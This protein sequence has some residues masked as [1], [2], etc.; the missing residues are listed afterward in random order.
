MSKKLNE[1]D[2]NYQILR[3]RVISQQIIDKALVL[4]SIDEDAITEEEEHY[5][6]VALNE[7]VS[8][9]VDRMCIKRLP[10][11]VE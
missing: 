2:P 10:G 6:L 5:M 9:W 8:E 11:D 7:A 4:Y 1:K 3:A